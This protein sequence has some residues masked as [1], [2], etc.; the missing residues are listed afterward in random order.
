MAAAAVL[1]RRPRLRRSA[2]PLLASRARPRGS[3]LRPQPI[4]DYEFV[5]EATYQVVLAPWLTIQ[6]DAQHHWHPG[7]NVLAAQGARTESLIKDESIFAVRRQMKFQ[8]VRP[9]ILGSSAGLLA[10]KLL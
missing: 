8:A 1:T 7:G 3:G 4:R 2:Q 6:L 9:A 10:S 5:A